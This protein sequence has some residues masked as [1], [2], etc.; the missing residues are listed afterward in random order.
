MLTIPGHAHRYCDGLTRRGFLT[1]GAAAGLTLPGLMRAEA[2]AGRRTHKS[3]IMVYLSGGMAHQDT[4]DL[5][6]NAP[7]E[8]RGTFNPIRTNLTG[9]TVCEHLPM[10][11]RCMDFA[12]VRL[13][14]AAFEQTGEAE[15]LPAGAGRAVQL[16]ESLFAWPWDASAHLIG[17]V[18]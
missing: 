15:R 10:L 6:P 9:V 7:A 11:A 16:A 17:V 3:V 12:A 13:I 5:K 2:A 1:V 4:F 18:P 14:A 8:V